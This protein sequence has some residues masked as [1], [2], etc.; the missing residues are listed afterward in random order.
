MRIAGKIQIEL[1]ARAAL[2]TSV[3]KEGGW[4]LRAKGLLTSNFHG[5]TGGGGGGGAE[6]ESERG[7]WRGDATFGP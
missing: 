7:G 1:E 5:V 6:P 2:E 4:E 3:R